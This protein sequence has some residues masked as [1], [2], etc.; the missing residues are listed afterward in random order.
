MTER[1]V[2][3]KHSIKSRLT[4]QFSS[5]MVLAMVILMVFSAL[6]LKR[7]MENESRRDLKVIAGLEMARL[8]QR[9]E[10]LLENTDRLTQ[11]SLV[12]NGLV[13][14]Q[15]RQTYLPELIENFSAGRHISNFSL[16]D[17]DGRPVFTHLGNI[18][19]DN[20]FKPLRRA[21]T[22]GQKSIFLQPDSNTL[23]VVSPIL[24]YSTTQ[25]AV[26]VTFDLLAI[27]KETFS[28]EESITHRLLIEER[29]LLVLGFESGE[30]Y[31]QVRKG[32]MVNT[33]I[34]QKLGLTL[35]VGT[36]ESKHLAA[37]QAILSQVFWVGLFLI[38]SAVGLAIWISG[39][40]ARPI[41]QLCQQIGGMQVG[42]YQLISPIGTQDELEIL[43]KAFDAR[44]L[45]LQQVHRNLENRVEERTLELKSALEKAESATQAKSEFLANMSH[46]IR[47][48]MNAIIGLT[49]LCL[50]THLTVQQKDYIHK[51]HN[52]ANSLLR[53][54]N[55]ILDFSKIEAGQL[56]IESIDFTLQE[57]L[58]SL[59]AMITLKAQEKQL[60]FILETSADIPPYLVGDPLR[61]GQILL[62]LSNNAV[63]FT[64]EGEVA[65]VTEVLEKGEDFVRLQF[66]VRDTGIGMTTEQA[67]KL[68]QAF[69]QGD[70]SITRQ[71]GGTGLG[72]VISKRLIEIM[73]GTIRSES[74][75]NIGSKFIF[76][77][78]LGIARQGVV[79]GATISSTEQKQKAVG[80]TKQEEGWQWEDGQLPL[81]VL[82]GSRILL[83]ED[84][85]I[86]QQVARELLEQANIIV[87]IAGNGQQAIDLLAQEPFDGILMDV[88]MPVMDG[89]TASREIRKKERFATLPILAMTANAMSG[90]RERC[91]DAGM[92]DHIAKPI[93]PENLFSTLARWVRP[94]LPQPL[95]T[96]IKQETGEREEEKEERP[97]LP[98]IP[99]ID[100]RTG[101]KYM[102]NNI[103]GYLGLLGKFRSNQGGAE[104]AIREALATQDLLTAERLAHTLK[105]VSAT[106]G[107]NTL[108]EKAEALESAIKGQSDPEQIETL[109]EKAAKELTKI[110]EALD[111]ALPK[112]NTKART[113]P[114]VEETKEM[115]TRRNALLRQ[116]ARQLESFDAEAENTLSAIRKNPVSQVTLS[117]VEKM[118]KQ[119]SQYD[120]EGAA[121]TLR[122]CL[123]NL[124]IDLD[125]NDE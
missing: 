62:N 107:A 87:T 23:V 44:T 15:G 85:E 105:G 92:Q 94:A 30:K 123:G 76:D 11:N 16:V 60:K 88:Q 65:V 73:G 51:T 19:D 14:S 54:I 78:R 66:T 125:V 95:P 104:A 50:R 64:E 45:N 72:L 112:E 39:N 83:V 31:I 114:V 109:L 21:L 86:N 17:F 101:L 8:E 25:G 55:D 117:W 13:D 59:S 41:L 97:T 47:T 90:D 24:F 71:Y 58:S 108:Q 36:N 118:E 89:L 75:P 9:L 113:K 57:V 61:L 33:P 98:E 52:S 48:P 46:E 82:S 5:F 27:G 20:A 2:Q 67:A 10:F 4:W 63:K 6:F 96:A 115:V 122:Q 106:I 56:D 102:G 49:H 3:T 116:M 12:K 120:F 22:R 32:P 35:E 84:N 119:V 53:I 7:F 74:Q 29:E 77:V 43:A 40:I 80:K 38:L 42:N 18:P 26:V 1:N 99:G 37:I 100:T 110:C 111:Q 91:L 70:S 34:M 79:E 68:F 121:D 93:D 81:T 103:K 124:G 28:S 69:S